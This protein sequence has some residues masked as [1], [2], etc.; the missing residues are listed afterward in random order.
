MSLLRQIQ[1]A[2]V[3]PKYQLADILRMCKILA[4]RLGH[5]DFKKWIEQ[6]LNGYVNPEQL[7]DYR[8]L[9][10]LGCKG[11][12]YGSYGEALQNAPIPSTYLPEKFKEYISTQYLFESVSSLENTISQANKMNKSILRV[13]LSSEDDAIL[14]GSSIYK[15]S[16]SCVE[17][18][19]D[20][21]TSALVA[22]LD[23]IK[24]RILD[25]VIEIEALNP[26]AGDALPHEK[27]IPDQK[28][29]YIYNKFIL[30]E[31]QMT[32]NYT[33]HFQ[34]STLGNF[35]NTVKDNARQQ[36]NQ[37]IHL[38]EEKRTLAEAASEI[39][40]ILKQLEQSNPTATEVEKVA[41][42]NDETTPSF[43]RRVIG[44]LQAS[45]ETAIDEFILENKYLK[46]VKSALKG[47]SQPSS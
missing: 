4:A 6:E 31:N 46:V 15:K 13:P 8:I 2:T 12:F 34:G 44:A 7:P 28:V 9:K 40:Q 16:M 14:I 11:N 41:H 39:Q 17:A 20:I 5:N 25:F 22:V 36:A 10:N 3:D 18:W 21:P 23:T 30:Q 1:D 33:N 38:S 45:G 27:L 43:K 37:N 26:N 29:N 35:A 19:K 47:W 24:N 42:I 32:E